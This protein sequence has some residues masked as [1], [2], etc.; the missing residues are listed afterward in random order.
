MVSSNAT[1]KILGG[2]SPTESD[3]Q[4]PEQE[5][6]V[7]PCHRFAPSP[8]GQWVSEMFS[9][10]LFCGLFLCLE[11]KLPFLFLGN[12]DA[13]SLHSYWT[14]LEGKRHKKAKAETDFYKRQSFLANGQHKCSPRLLSK[15]SNSLPEK[16]FSSSIVTK[17]WQGRGFAGWCPPWL[18]FLLW[19]VVFL[20]WLAVRSVL[21]QRL[22]FAVWVLL[23]HTV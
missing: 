23:H 13:R 10:K 6:I 21:E 2:R 11:T 5:I 15:A 14:R 1:G 7:A 12:H 9:W 3:W 16:F 8:R 17:I 19:T 20:K 4:N 18:Q 22:F